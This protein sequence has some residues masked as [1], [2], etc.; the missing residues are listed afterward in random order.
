[1]KKMIILAVVLMSS[2]GYAADKG[3][4]DPNKEVNTCKFLNVLCQSSCNGNDG[5]LAQCRTSFD[6]CLKNVTSGK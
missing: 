1:M 4:I 6:T 2:V 3:S 5:C